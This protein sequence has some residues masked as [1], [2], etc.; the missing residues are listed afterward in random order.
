MTSDEFYVLAERLRA[1]GAT[2]V[3]SGDLKVTFAA[4]VPRTPP[5][6]KPA[7]K[8][9]TADLDYEEWRSRAFSGDR[10]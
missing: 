10:D 1:L 5:F 7:A 4:P 9:A 8:R 2:V 3:E 6:T